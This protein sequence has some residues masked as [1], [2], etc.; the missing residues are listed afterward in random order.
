MRNNGLLRENGV[1]QRPVELGKS[2]GMKQILLE[3]GGL[4]TSINWL[5]CFRPHRHRTTIGR[6]SRY[7]LMPKMRLNLHTLVFPWNEY[8]QVLSVTCQWYTLSE[9]IL[10]Q[11]GTQ[12]LVLVWHDWNELQN[13]LACWHP[14]KKIHVRRFTSILTQ[15]KIRH[16]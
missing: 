6:Y 4:M 9:W 14:Y 1:R 3:G 10:R 13:Q 16:S 2:L 12:N 11:S 8:I 15:H 5:W 7:L